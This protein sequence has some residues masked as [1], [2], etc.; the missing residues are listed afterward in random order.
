MP[1]KMHNNSIYLYLFECESHSNEAIMRASLSLLVV[2]VMAVGGAS[3]FRYF[4]CCC[5]SFSVCSF[6]LF[7]ME[8][9]V[10]IPN[11]KERPI[12]DIKRWNW[13]KNFISTGI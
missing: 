5:H 6:V 10:R 11:V 7:Q 13:R 8:L 4:C 9:T 12:L 1:K 2:A 3:L